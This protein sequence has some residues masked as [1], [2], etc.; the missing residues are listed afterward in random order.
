MK[1][2][3]L[4]LGA[5]GFIGNA[6]VE[7]L[8]E[9]NQN[10]IFG[11]DLYSDKLDNSLEKRNFEF[12]KGDINS[13]NKWIENQIKKCD[14]IIPLVAIATPNMYVK[15]P[16]KIFQ[17]NFESN[18]KIIKLIAKYKKRLIFPSTS[19]V[20]G[21]SPDKT[22][23]EYSTNLVVGPVTKP[24]WIYSISK[25][26]LDRI[27]IALGEQKKLEYTIF[28]PFNWIG[29]KID[30]LKQA[31]L[32]NGRVLTIFIYNILNNKDIVLVGN[33]KQKR[34]FT[35]IDDG[36]SALIK[37][38]EN[39]KNNLNKKIFNIGNPN[40]NISIKKLAEILIDRYQILY[41]NKYKGKLVYK[42]EKEF[43]G[44]GFEDI[45][46]RVPDISEAKKYLNWTPKNNV[47]SSIF[48][49]LKFFTDVN[50]F[51]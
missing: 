21:M 42:S 37:I 41:P 44:K 26:L 23:N 24:R 32:K 7:K 36:I 35:Y 3:I 27:I 29:P 12:I 25:Q 14:V 51:L 45:P 30:S 28:R 40:N 6:L 2:K 22:F 1:K 19:E 16:L 8:S 50:K 48:K 9:N 31:K 5:N 4:I 11:L 15:D 49:T 10:K 33:G 13:K 34:S 43:Y 39:K 46:L 17:L 18:L 20:Y 47:D 38:I